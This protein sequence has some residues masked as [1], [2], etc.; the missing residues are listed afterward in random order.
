MLRIVVAFARDEKAAPYVDALLSCGLAPT[1]TWLANPQRLAGLDPDILL[2]EAGGLLLTGGA[3]L[4]P[5]LYGETPAPGVSLDEPLHD[6]D[7][8]EWD[9]LTGARERRLPVLAI[10]RGMQLLN[11]FHGGSLWQDLEL[12]AGYPG[13]DFS[14]DAGFAP[15][16]QAHGVEAVADGHPAQRYYARAGRVTVNSRHHQAVRRVGDGLVTAAV[17]PDGVVEAMAVEDP[18]WWAWG[19]QWHPEN[20][21]AEPVHRA[22]FTEFLAAAESRR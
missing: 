8:M 17:A 14:T 21:V 13:H 11:V 22:L 2:D 15:D 16:R 7:R 19:V 4:D 1:E 20:L 9:L 3:D 10:C 12:Q 5:A 6:R 18:R